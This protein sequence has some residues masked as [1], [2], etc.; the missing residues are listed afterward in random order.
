MPYAIA[1]K[2]S[3]EKTAAHHIRL[4]Q[5]R[6]VLN[7]QHGFF[8]ESFV[9][10]M[11]HAAGKDP[12]QFRRD[13][14]GDQPRFRAVLDRAAALAEWGSALPEREGR[15]IAVTECFGSFVAEV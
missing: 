11:A 7:S 1:E 3:D 4:G 5:W 6:S 12:Y 13:L 15:G 2:K 9:D 8:K 10:E 14:L